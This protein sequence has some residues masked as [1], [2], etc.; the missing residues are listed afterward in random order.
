MIFFISRINLRVRALDLKIHP[1]FA[2]KKNLMLSIPLSIHKAA[3][4]GQPR[5]AVGSGDR[6][7]PRDT[8]DE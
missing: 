4:G 5:R 8:V 2:S 7:L 6:E 1:N 3:S